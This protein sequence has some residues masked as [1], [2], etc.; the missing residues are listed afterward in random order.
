[1]NPGRTQAVRVHTPEGVAFSYRIASPVLR[2]GALVVDKAAVTAACLTLASVVRIFG[3]ISVDLAG[4][5]LTLLFFLISQ[6]YH[7]AC[8]W[9]W[10]GQ[11]LGKRLLRLRVVDSGGLRLSFTQVTMRNLL[12]FI[13]AL[14][15][16]YLVGGGAAFLSAKGQRLGDLVAGTLV[17]WNPEETLPEIE[18]EQGEKYNSLRA[19]GPVMARLRQS[20]SPAEARVAR[21]AIARR[22]TLEP[23]VRVRLFS[24]FAAHFRQVARAPEGLL[25]GVADEQFVRNVVDVLYHTR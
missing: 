21:L 1:M 24:D 19:H 6:G 5:L 10:G 11:S 23:E 7:I 8:E 15:V 3:F 17:I 9:L 4:L 16:L 22:D 25:R 18:R 12:R 13:D 20:V 14:P 2:A